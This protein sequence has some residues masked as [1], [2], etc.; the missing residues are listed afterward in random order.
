MEEEETDIEGVTKSSQSYTFKIKVE[1]NGDGTLKLTRTGDDHTALDFVNTY[2]AGASI[3]FAGTKII[4]KRDLKAGDSFTFTVKGSD[5]TDE[6][7]SN[8]VKGD[9]DYPTIYFDEDD[10]DNEYTYEVEEEETDIEGVTKSIK[11]IGIA[12]CWER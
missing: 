11:K 3:T 9:I 12:S 10:I 7:V 4:D 2:K 5:G 6:S 1:D 8:D